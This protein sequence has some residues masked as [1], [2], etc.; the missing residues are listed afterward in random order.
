MSNE[1]SM[2]LA[3]RGVAHALKAFL[4]VL[5]SQRRPTVGAYATL[6]MAAAKVCNCGRLTGSRGHKPPVAP[7]LR[8]SGGDIGL[9]Q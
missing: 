2:H 1:Q 5:S 3:V 6:G 8:Y 9:S 7:R 4:L